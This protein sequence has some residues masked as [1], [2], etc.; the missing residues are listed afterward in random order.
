MV[1]PLKMGFT[2][3]AGDD[4][5]RNG[6]DAIRQNAQAAADGI[7]GVSP[8]KCVRRENAVWIWDTVSPT[9]YLLPNPDGALV[10]RGTPYPLPDVKPS[11]NW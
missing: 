6:D 3:P 9:H 4:Y 1:D 10:A 7:A 11:L 8:V 5:L 2:L